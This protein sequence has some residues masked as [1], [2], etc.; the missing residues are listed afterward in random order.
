MAWRTHVIECDV[1]SSLHTCLI[2]H[3]NLVVGGHVLLWL[4][5][6]A[7]TTAEVA[8]GASTGRRG[9]ARR[10]AVMTRRTS[11]TVSDVHHI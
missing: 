7:S 9:Q 1:T 3:V 6:P 4:V 10:S 11:R 2:V 5:L 8:F